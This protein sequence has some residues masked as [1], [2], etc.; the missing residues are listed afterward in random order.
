MNIPKI[1]SQ[2]LGVAGLGLVLHD[3]HT[4]GKI[5]SAA[6]QRKSG[7]EMGLTAYE[8]TMMQNS[9]SV[10]QMEVK[11]KL[12]NTLMDENIT[13]FFSGMSG[14]T[15]GFTRMLVDNVIPLG[16]SLGAVLAKPAWAS[17]AF[18]AGLL[19]YGLLFVVREGLGALKPNDLSR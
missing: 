14:Y 5:E 9:P 1:A 2:A 18:G 17:K 13:E 11:K 8:N 4:L 12:S 7:A 6:L 19:A 10:V 15:K 16:L 3:S